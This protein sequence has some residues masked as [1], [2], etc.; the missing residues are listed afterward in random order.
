MSGPFYGKYRGKVVNPIDPLGLGRL[1]VQVPAVY[2]DAALNW[3][4]PCLP[5]AGSQVGLLAVPPIGANVWVEFEAGDKDSPIWSGCFW[6]AG[7]APSG[8]TT[9]PFTK[10]FATDL[11]TI[12][13]TD[14]GAEPGVEIKTK[15]GSRLAITATGIV[16]DNGKGGK[17]EMTGPN[18]SVNGGALEVT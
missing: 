13:L 15:D 2:G 8:A 5:F 6:S 10:V 12:T 11:V 3:A 16:I 17:I 7:E 1:Q 14:V 9:A 4:L 18:V